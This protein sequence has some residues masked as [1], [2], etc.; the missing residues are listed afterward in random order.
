M[1][2][3]KESGSDGARPARPKTEA[4]L[5]REREAAALRTNLQRRKRQA[6]ARREGSAGR[7]EDG[8]TGA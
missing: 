7:P 4:L 1:N 5:R 8:S 2:E 6:R 3:D